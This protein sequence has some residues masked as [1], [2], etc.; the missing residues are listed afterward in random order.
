MIKIYTFFIISYFLAFLLTFWG[1]ERFRQWSL[2]RGIFDIPNERSSHKTPTPRGGGLVIASVSL[3]FFLIYCVFFEAGSFWGYFAGAILI[4]LISW[5][6]D[7]YTISVIWRFIAHSLAAFA[8]IWT[9][10]FWEHIYIPFWGELYLA[11]YGIL[12]TFFWIV[13]LINAYNFMDG[14]DGIAGVQALA[15][16]IGWFVSSILLDI[17]HTAF[18]GGI[19]AVSALAFLRHNWSPAKIFMGDIGSAFLGFTFAV[20]PLLALEEKRGARQ[21]EMILPILGVFMVFPFVFDSLWTF[22]KRLVR[23]E[24]VWQAHRKHIYQ[25]LVI[26]GFTHSKVS[27]IYALLSF[28]SVLGVCFWIYFR[29]F[30]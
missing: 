28:L 17:N 16:G 2:K 18:Y 30:L 27:L 20:M 7:L 4:C 29:N 25:K 15:A 5:L 9:L 26:S 21:T 1:I 3:G 22:I 23:G 10:G 11:K 12:L 24:K 6:D 19:L 13:W 14:I 8:V